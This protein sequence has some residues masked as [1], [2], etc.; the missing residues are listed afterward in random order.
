VCKAF[1]CFQN[2]F[3]TL[4]FVPYAIRNEILVIMCAQCK[5]PLTINRSISLW[6]TPLAYNFWHTNEPT[7]NVKVLPFHVLLTWCWNTLVLKTRNI[8]WKLPYPIATTALLDTRLFRGLFA[9]MVKPTSIGSSDWQD[10][11]NSPKLC[12]CFQ[13]WIKLHASWIASC[14]AIILILFKFYCMIFGGSCY[15]PNVIVAA[16]CLITVEVP[17]K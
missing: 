10:G 5:Q 3:T 1:N 15:F 8:I 4:S 9:G 14:G 7:D 16:R 12:Q 2:I 17:E 6:T 11:S 13:I